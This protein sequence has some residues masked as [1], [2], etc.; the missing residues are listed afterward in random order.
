MG[1]VYLA[2]NLVNKKK[3]VGYTSKSLKERKLGHLKKV[4]S[5]SKLLFHRAIRKY[6]EEK[7][8]WISFY[9]HKCEIKLQEKEIQLIKSFN[10]KSPNGYNLTDGG[11]GLV[12]C[13]LE[14][15]EKIGSAQRGR[16]RPPRTE[17]YRAKLSRATHLR[18]HGPNSKYHKKVL[19]DSRAKIFLEGRGENII[20]AIGSLNRGKKFSEERK[21]KLRE[22]R[23]RF[24]E[25]GAGEALKNRY[26]L[27]YAGKPLSIETRLKMSKAQLARSKKSKQ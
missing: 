5:G 11:G 4:K 21:Q 13:T 3:Y 2:I 23:K 27:E 18:F 8:T 19:R 22:S 20:A 14:T 9:T 24:L 17:E 12:G 1:C 25:S 6:G 16:K 7:F 10:C 15:R 26:K